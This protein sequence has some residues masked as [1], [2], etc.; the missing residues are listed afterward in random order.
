[1][2]FIALFLTLFISACTP[3]ISN[4]TNLDGEYYKDLVIKSKIHKDLKEYLL[5]ND[6]KLATV[7][8]MSYSTI[9]GLANV[10]MD[11]QR[12][13][14]FTAE[15]NL[16][17][18]NILGLYITSEL[19]GVILEAPGYT[20]SFCADYNHAIISE[21]GTFGKIEYN[22]YLSNMN[23]EQRQKLFKQPVLSDCSYDHL[24][25]DIFYK[26]RIQIS[27]SIS[28]LKIVYTKTKENMPITTLDNYSL[29]IR[30]M[31]DQASLAMLTDSELLQALKDYKLTGKKKII[32]PIIEPI[33]ENKNNENLTAPLPININ[34]STTAVDLDKFKTQCKE[35]GFKL[36]TTD[37]GNCV[38]Q[39][40]K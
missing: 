39:L 11:G 28:S 24:L 15:N 40:M 14:F 10:G 27:S 4:V 12:R 1:M 21:N 18:K 9:G 16:W 17:L 2:K 30:D 8:G 19:S 38:L 32:E 13:N 6:I 36:G 23:E 31:A 35:L 26:K 29:I 5:K 20:L 25:G 34:Q 33:I 3:T 37:Y 22:Y 7:I